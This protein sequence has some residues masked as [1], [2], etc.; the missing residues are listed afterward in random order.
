MKKNTTLSI[1]KDL[2]FAQEINKYCK[3]IEKVI[4][5]NIS[6]AQN[7]YY[8]QSGQGIFSNKDY[9]SIFT[10]TGAIKT[11][12]LNNLGPSKSFFNTKNNRIS[13]NGEAYILRGSRYLAA[14]D[15]RLST[16]QK[17]NIFYED[18]YDGIELFRTI[19]MVSPNNQYEQISPVL[20]YIK[21][22]IITL[23]NAYFQNEKNRTTN[24]DTEEY[25]ILR[26]ELIKIGRQVTTYFY[27]SLLGELDT[28]GFYQKLSRVLSI[29]DKVREYLINQYEV[30]ILSSRDIV[31]PEASH[32]LVLLSFT[33]LLL[34]QVK[35]VDTVIG[36]PAGSTELSYLVSSAYSRE[37]SSNCDLVLVPISL[38]SMQAQ[39]G[40][41]SL[42]DTELP[43][44]WE[45]FKTTIDGKHL[46]IVDD[47]SS[48][49]AT[50][51][52]IASSIWKTFESTKVDVAVAEAD[53][54]RTRLDLR[55]HSKRNHYANTIIYNYSVG[56]LPIS[57]S[58]WRKHDLK[59]VSEA[60]HIANHYSEK[61]KLLSEPNNKYR[62][63]AEVFCEESRRPFGRRVAEK[64]WEK[65]SKI[66][67][68]QGTFLSNF[69][70]VP[71][72]WQ[73]Q[74]F[75]SVEHAYQFAKFDLSVLSSIS[76]ELKATISDKF[77]VDTTNLANLFVLEENPKTIKRISD[78]LKNHNLVRDNWD[79][80][81]VEKMIELLIK[82]FSVE[83]MRIKLID[84]GA[85]YLVEGND[86]DD[87]FWG[88]C[89]ENDKLRGRNILGIIIMNIRQKII[90]NDL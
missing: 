83:E 1:E 84:T 36:L 90:S 75:P 74:T 16:P 71:I 25:W 78:L 66:L 69:Y 33:S 20:D 9:A 46:V 43:N 39:Y 28:N 88:A 7:N 86:W 44:Y 18:L 76:S 13:R 23:T 52:G 56:V 61:A 79:K 81:R 87:T 58:L 12:S 26:E 59:E 30:Y 38:H 31:R 72:S 45:K 27:L 21:N 64:D 57:K 10:F 77:D 70:H 29:A 62:I 24:L 55:Q 60:F 34:K 53:I 11:Q 47:N 42:L 73:S 15:P 35:S 85:A 51:D 49:G 37:S 8:V 6:L 17:L 67:K 63:E 82:K 40:K 5:K 41:Q 68:F 80:Y 14:I 89:T 22:S 3:N 48:S 2:F 65:E 19:D 54:I 32:P 4:Y 50:L